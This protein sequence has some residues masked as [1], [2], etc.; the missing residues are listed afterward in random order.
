MSSDAAYV[1]EKPR[2]QPLPAYLPPVY[3]CLFRIVDNMGYVS[4]DINRYSVPE[5]FVGKKVQV[6]KS[7]D[8]IEIYFGRRKIADHKRC[9]GKSNA[10]SLDPSHH[11]CKYPSR[12][13]PSR[14]EKQLC[15]HSQTLDLYVAQIK[16]RSR[17]RA[18]R[19][20][21]KLLDLQRTYP[22][23]AFEAACRQALH[24]GLFDLTRLERM[25]LERIAGDFFCIPEQ[26]EEF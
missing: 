2:L 9:I 17:G 13:S 23:P 4:V 16:K 14:E 20:L 21:R 6:H 10:R 12:N 18:V 8:R 1:V 25:I 11:L 26:E 15:G 22:P 3:Q 5:R 19:P 24:Y 7:W